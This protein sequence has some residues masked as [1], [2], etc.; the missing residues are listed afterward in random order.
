[1]HKLDN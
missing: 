1:V